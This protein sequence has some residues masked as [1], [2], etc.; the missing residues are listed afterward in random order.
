MGMSKSNLMAISTGPCVC[1]GCYDH[2]GPCYANIDR[3]IDTVLRDLDKVEKERD[4]VIKILSYLKIP[5][6]VALRSEPRLHE[7][8]TPTGNVEVKWNTSY[9]T[10]HALIS[11]L[12]VE[13]KV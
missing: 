8:N 4:E 12:W 10:L 2:G 5:V 7:V 1:Q 6:E 13:G 3:A 9:D 11:L